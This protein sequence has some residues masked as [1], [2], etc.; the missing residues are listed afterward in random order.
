MNWTYSLLSESSRTALI[1]ELATQERITDFSALRGA[2]AAL[3]PATTTPLICDMPSQPYIAGFV[4]KMVLEAYQRNRRLAAR[5]TV[6][7]NIF[8]Q[9]GTPKQN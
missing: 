2:C 8:S 1:V 7:N 6:M 9:V 4:R 5:K 3:N